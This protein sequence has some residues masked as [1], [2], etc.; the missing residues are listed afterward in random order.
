MKFTS[1]FN[2]HKMFQKNAFKALGLAIILFGVMFLS[3]PVNASGSFNPTVKIIPYHQ[4]LNGSL[5]AAGFGTG[6][7]FNSQG[8]ILTNA[9]VVYNDELDR[10]WD[11]FSVCVQSSPEDIPDCRFTAS[12]KRY[13]EHIDL[14]VLRVDR[15][16]AW[17]AIPSSFSSIQLN[18][19]V[20]PDVGDP[21]TVH[22]Y[23]ASGGGTM[24]VTQG[25]I[26]GFDELNGYDYYKT[27]ADIDAGNSGGA[28]F[29]EDGDLIGVP[30]YIVS[31]YENSGRVL[32]ATE[33]TK[34]LNS[35]DGDDGSVNESATKELR[36]DWSNF[37]EA[38]EEGGYTYENNPK[39]SVKVPLGWEFIGVS[40]TTMALYKRNNP[41]AVITVSFSSNGFV[42]DLPLS[43][44]LELLE[45]LYETEYKDHQFTTVD[46]VEAL[47]VWED[48]GDRIAHVIK[49][50]KGYKNIEIAYII[51]K[52][53]ESAVLKGV[54]QFLADFKMASP[55]VDNP[56]PLYTLDIAGYPY[57]AE[58]PGDWR[59]VTEDISGTMLATL[60]TPVKELEAVNMYYSEH[61]ADL[62]D[63]NVSDALDY[64]IENYVPE[65]AK[66]I[67]KSAKLMIDGLK[68]WMVVYEYTA[69][70]IKMK[71]VTFSVLSN[72]YELNFDYDAEL[73][74]FDAGLSK[75]LT[76][77]KS[78][79]TSDNNGEGEFSLPLSG[80]TAQEGSL[81][82]I[83]GHRYEDSIRNLV[84][85]KVLGGY[86]DGTF[87]PENSVNRAEAL[88]IILQSLRSLQ[89]EEGTEAFVMPENFNN[90]SDLK[91]SE[92]YATY[93]AEG[94]DKG[95]INGYP[96]GTFR[97][98]NTVNLAEA[99]KM[100]LE[101]HDAN[102]W[103]G[104]SDPW[105][106]KYFDSAYSLDLLPQDLTDPGKLLTRAELSYIVD[107]LVNQ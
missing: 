74:I 95:I 46:G 101:A 10:P 8:D 79:K 27:D 6:T 53:D 86:P 26:S 88:K 94:V 64:E 80:G 13:D 15:T 36:E 54:N 82:D 24:S 91:P 105:H 65:D 7:I 3:T 76:L 92:W 98:G 67:Q 42:Y 102:V 37:F 19:E 104:D 83:A 1:F 41:S 106:K 51:P 33:V 14:A 75:F 68:G 81:S 85:M 59:I 89:Q 39:I 57:T 23:P 38:R 71:S 47:H 44:R 16:P 87:K 11:A 55:D 20:V 22:G 97:G 90:F 48:E 25:Q 4:Y 18:D 100:T 107:Q 56:N 99:L 31:Y 77:I 69:G 84:E 73:D 40:D 30:S 52:N 43:Y 9:H 60:A 72:K 49:L 45:G 17:G 28:M 29:S 21:V 62:D 78:I 50:E 32:K 58:A 63:L 61:N 12:L 103:G 66:I 34:W 35:K 2:P 5:D 93:V 70:E 96:D